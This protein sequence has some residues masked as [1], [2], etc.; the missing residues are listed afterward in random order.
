M[1][2][3]PPRL[4][5]VLALSSDRVTV[6][7]VGELLAGASLDMVLADNHAQLLELARTAAPDVVLLN[8]ELRQA[9]GL[10]TCRA[11]RGDPLL[12]DLPILVITAR[13]DRS[14]RLAA[15]E[16]G[17]DD[18]VSKPFDLDDL[19][20]RLRA[21]LKAHRY[22]KLIALERRFEMLAEQATQPILLVDSRH[23][24]Q[25]A[26][27]AAKTLLGLDPG[28][29]L[30][31]H[32]QLASRFMRRPEAD[33][34]ALE[35]GMMPEQLLLLERPREAPQ[36]VRW[37]SCALKPVPNDPERPYMVS[38]NEI[39]SVV[40]RQGALWSVK[41]LVT[42]KLRTP[43]NGLLAP[44]EMLLAEELS[45]DAREL[46]EIIRESSQRLAD[47]VDGI[48]R[49]FES[50]RVGGGPPARVDELGAVLPVL[51]AQRGIQTPSLTVLDGSVTQIPLSRDALEAIFDELMLNSRKFHPRNQPHMQV[52]V[53]RPAPTGLR[54]DIVDDGRRLHPDQLRKLHLP[55]Y[56]AEDTPTGEVPGEGLGLTQV[57]RLVWE[58]GGRISFSNRSDAPGLCVTFEFSLRSRNGVPARRVVESANGV[59]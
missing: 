38:I 14:S 57:A 22:R 23:R 27:D 47:T 21:I 10:D 48:H 33:W 3:N 31:W 44:V 45:P 52:I 56:Q 25:Y 46:A 20:L 30:R 2:D 29:T 18:F 12:R 34:I 55:F 8:Y 24:L 35:Q 37:F 7:L 26:N 39:T 28:S 41:T 13:D 9:T 1:T 16:A 11:I 6:A 40:Q 50:P 19:E 43:V 32:E 36:P 49:Y 58:A 15:I 4:N 53:S 5:R 51:A 54:V 59:A 17:A 42:H